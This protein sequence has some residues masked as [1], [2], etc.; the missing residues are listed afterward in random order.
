MDAL[1]AIPWTTSP[2]T[3]WGI[4]AATTAGVIIRPFSWP[5]FIWALA[6]ALLLV[7]LGLLSA[8]DAGVLKGTDVYLFLMGMMLPS[9]RARRACS[10]G[11]PPARP[12]SPADRRRGCSL[13]STRSAPSVTVILSN[14]ATAA[15]RQPAR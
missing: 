15:N 6:G 13:S 14:D 1:V 8:A 9:V 4:A 12:A 5:E 11:S 7:A 10:T 3:I 2:W